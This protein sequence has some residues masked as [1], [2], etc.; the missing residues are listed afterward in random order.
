MLNW[1]LCS[2]FAKAHLNE[3]ISILHPPPYQ[4]N[5]R[6][7]SLRIKAVQTKMK[8]SFLQITE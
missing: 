3:R 2:F 8:L 1:L 4:E 6:I 5:F 7:T